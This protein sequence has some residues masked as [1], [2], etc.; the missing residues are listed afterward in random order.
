M[1]KNIL[2]FTAAVLLIACQKKAE[3]KVTNRVS[4]CMIETISYGDY[5]ISGTLITNAASSVEHIKDKKSNFP[6]KYPFVFYMTSKGNRVYLRTKEE[7]ELKAEGT[8]NVIIENSTEVQ[9]P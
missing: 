9:A 7:F 8:L 3:I 4:N 1:K 6:K 5:R 2:I